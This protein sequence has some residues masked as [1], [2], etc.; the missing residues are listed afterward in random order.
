MD[1]MSKAPVLN[2]GLVPGVSLLGSTLNFY[3]VWACVVPGDVPLK[4]F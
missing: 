3:E 2:K 1:M 4:E